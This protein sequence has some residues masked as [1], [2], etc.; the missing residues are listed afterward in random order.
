ME[1][2]L[3]DTIT[4][5]ELPMGLVLSLPTDLDLPSSSKVHIQDHEFLTIIHATSWHPT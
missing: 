2:H 5:P 4:E 3:Y 1:D